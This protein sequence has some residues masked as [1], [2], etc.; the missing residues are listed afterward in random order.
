MI[1]L[2]IIISILLFISFKRRKYIVCGNRRYSFSRHTYKQLYYLRLVE[3]DI[4]LGKVV[5]YMNKHNLP[6]KEIGNK[7]KEK[8]NTIVI[9]TINQKENIPG[10]AINKKEIRLCIN[11]NNSIIH[12]FYVMMHEFAHTITNSDGHTQEFHFIFE[13][14]INVADKLNLIHKST[15]TICGSYITI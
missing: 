8:Y 14:L 4:M 10:Y 13:S 2:I 11:E 6:T 7:V 5:K 1:K 12:T 9:G 15:S 3:L